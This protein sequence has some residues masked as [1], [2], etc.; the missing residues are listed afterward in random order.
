MKGNIIYIISA[1]II[2]LCII[3]AFLINT[4]SG[5]TYFVLS[6]LTILSL[7]WAGHLIYFY[8]TTFKEEL[9]EDFE[10]YRA[11]VVNAEGITLEEFEKNLGYYK[12]KFNRKN[13]IKEKT[14][15]ICKI[16]FAF[17]VAGLFIMAMFVN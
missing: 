14:I 5:F 7:A 16:I 10:Y 12:K 8:C 11:E 6:L 4:W 15:H 1:I 17:G 9:T 13:A 2:V 3:F